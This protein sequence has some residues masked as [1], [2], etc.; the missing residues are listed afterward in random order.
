ME[1]K[2]YY[3]ILGVNPDSTLR[4]IKK[5]YRKLALQFHPDKN[6]GNESATLEFHEIQEAYEI[7]SDPEKRQI[8]NYSYSGSN[9]SGDTYKK[10]SSPQEIFAL[11][12]NLTKQV[13]ISDTFRMNQERLAAKLMRILSDENI[14]LMQEAGLDSLNHHFVD[15]IIFISRPLKYRFIDPIIG[16]L[17]DLAGEDISQKEKILEYSKARKYRN[18]WE[19]AYPFL[20]IILTLTICLAIYFAVR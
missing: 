16:K 2:D 7:L 10:P 9:Y 5:N 4:E 20:V 1:G 13:V 19:R 17:M 6:E 8:Y 3:E 11:A 12:S 15:E 14:S 18:S